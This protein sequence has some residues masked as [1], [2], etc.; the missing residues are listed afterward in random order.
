MNWEF[1]PVPCSPAKLQNGRECSCSWGTV[2]ATGT[3]V[4]V[5]VS[6]PWI[7]YLT[8]LVNQLRPSIPRESL[9]S[10]WSWEVFL[11]P[12]YGGKGLHLWFVYLSTCDFHAES[13]RSTRKKENNHTLRLVNFYQLQIKRFQW[14][15]E[16]KYHFYRSRNYE[17]TCFYSLTIIFGVFTISSD[18]TGNCSR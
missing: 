16:K 12:I 5:A 13:T 18:H 4:S 6:L 10:V 15:V 17:I 9:D 8:S 3:M 14:L 7:L 2:L 1:A 11:I